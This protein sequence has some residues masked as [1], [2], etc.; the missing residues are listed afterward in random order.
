MRSRTARLLAIAAVSITGLL[1]GCATT[2]PV[3]LK[4][5]RRLVGA[6]ADVRLDVQL[7]TEQLSPSQ[8]I[9]ITYD[10]TNNRNVTIG[11]AEL[12]PD[13]T[14]DAETQTVTVSLGSEVP[15]EQLLPRIVAIP[16]GQKKTFSA[17]ATLQV[18]L[19]RGGGSPL[20]RYPNAVRV[21]LNYLGDVKPFQALVGMPERALRDPQLA[22][23]LFPKWLER[24]EA[25]FTNT[26]PMHWVAGAPEESDLTRRRNP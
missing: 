10:V 12:I 24:N 16:P 15:G 26:L 3:S 1:S 19:P 22:A 5:P 17:L 2:A 23:E 21:K 14:Y 6:D 13:T 20:V 8:R 25:L 9:P 11:V 7:F 4:E 18:M